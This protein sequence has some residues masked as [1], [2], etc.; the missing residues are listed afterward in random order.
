M[1]KGGTSISARRAF[2]E[3]LLE[4]LQGRE[5]EAVKPLQCLDDGVTGYVF[6]LVPLRASLDYVVAAIRDE[7]TLQPDATSSRISQL[8]TLLHIS[9]DPL[10]IEKL[11]FVNSTDSPHEMLRLIQR[12]GIDLFDSHWAQRAA[13]I[14]VALDF[15]FPV[16]THGPARQ[17]HGKRDLGHNLYD[18]CYAHDFSALASCFVGYI[19]ENKGDR[20]ICLCAACSPTSPT[21]RIS[22]S[23]VD[24]NEANSE[25]YLPPF[26]RAYL[27]HLL[28]THEMSAHT[29]LVMHNL[30]VLDAMFAS[31]RSIIHES[32]ADVFSA[33]VDRFVDEYDEE[34]AIFKEAAV[35][36]NEVDRARGKGRIA[37]EKAKQDGVDV[38]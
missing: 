23:S 2:S 9:L 4:T 21:S 15:T 10:P 16:S 11:R 17:R 28:H 22:H 30:T 14:G 34:L 8:S 6:D 18:A 29:L 5:A 3:S 31:V 35:I 20:D 38:I 1:F 32:G 33:E 36:W 12:I 25:E 7:K 19:H 13:D 27:H 24:M 26:T 37:R